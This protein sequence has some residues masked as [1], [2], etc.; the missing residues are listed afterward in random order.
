[1]RRLRKEGAST[2]QKNRVSSLN[3]VE[4]C[5]RA[6]KRGKQESPDL[7]DSLI[8][9]VDTVIVCVFFGGGRNVCVQYLGNWLKILPS[10]Y[11]TQLL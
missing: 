4:A 8:Y 6:S 3:K 9:R 11:F 2:T 1:M 5:D 10:C 7:D